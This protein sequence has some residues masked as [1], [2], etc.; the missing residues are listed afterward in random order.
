MP[1]FF[2]KPKTFPLKLVGWL[3]TFTEGQPCSSMTWIQERFKVLKCKVQAWG[4]NALDLGMVFFGV[5]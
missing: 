5:Q 2:S 1:G 3:V 4:E